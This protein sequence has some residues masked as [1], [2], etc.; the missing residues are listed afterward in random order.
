MAV[1]LAQLREAIE[2]ETDASTDAA[3]QR[4]L[5]T[6]SALVERYASGAPVSV[7]DKHHKNGGL[8]GESTQFLPSRAYLSRR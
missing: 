3:L 2:I 4:M 7:S 5:D 8:V 6:A 1:T